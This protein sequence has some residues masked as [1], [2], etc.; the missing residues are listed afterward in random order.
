MMDLPLVIVA[1]VL[2]WYVM[3]RDGNWT[4]WHVVLLHWPRNI[5]GN[6]INTLLALDIV[7][8]HR[9]YSITQ[10]LPNNILMCFQVIIL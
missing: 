9:L 5:V 2:I 10:R 6:Y 1:C 4:M 3:S 8:S 7:M